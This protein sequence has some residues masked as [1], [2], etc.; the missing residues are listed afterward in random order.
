MAFP[1]RD[2]GVYLIPKSNKG[3]L[4]NKVTKVLPKRQG[5]LELRYLIDK[6]LVGAFCKK[7]ARLCQL[8][9][10]G[11]ECMLGIHFLNS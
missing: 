11:S 9:V 4:P 2:E 10:I 3:S 7:C 5:V 1:D 8:L 6:F